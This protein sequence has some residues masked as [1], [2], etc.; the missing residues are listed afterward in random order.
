MPRLRPETREQSRLRT[1]AAWSSGGL[2]LAVAA[3]A[4]YAG[5]TWCG[6]GRARRTAADEEDQLLDRFMPAYDVVDRHRI[7]VQAPAD[8]TLA[9][10]GNEPLLQS[11]VVRAIFRGREILLGARRDARPPRRGLLDEMQSIG[12]VVLAETPGREVVLGAATEPWQA[13]VTFRS[14]PPDGFLEFADPDYV[15]IAW[16]LRAD[17]IGGTASVL[18]TETRAIAT[19]ADA[20]AKFRRY[21]SLLSPG[22]RLIRR[23]LLRRVKARAEQV[24]VPRS[25]SGTDPAR[26]SA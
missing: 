18:H 3:Y 21:W 22:I 17:P 5:V 7:L 23:A 20:R 6:Y 15:K 9:A 4:A 11:P 16:T 13:N 10:A 1:V 12:W 25:P 2:G 14:I 26:D 24:S 19:D 8:V